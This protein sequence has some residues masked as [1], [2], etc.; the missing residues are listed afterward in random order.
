[1]PH[2][3]TPSTLFSEAGVRQ[4]V[5]LYCKL[6]GLPKEVKEQLRIPVDRW[7]KSK[8][9]QSYV[10]KMIDL[11]IAFE[12][13]FLR[14]IRDELSFRFSL[15]GSLYLEE[16]LAARG[17]LKRELQA[18]YDCRSRAVHEGKLPEKLKVNGENVPMR[19][20]IERSQDLLKRCLLKVIESGQLPDWSTIELGGGERA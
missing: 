12:S 8:T 20:F 6:I 19:Q 4:A 13:F 11:G 3:F 10:D 16:G 17:R 2:G 5:V 15:R 7:M 18:I 14:G 9:Q 1:M